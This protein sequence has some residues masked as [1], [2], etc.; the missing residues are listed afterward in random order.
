MRRWLTWGLGLVAAAALGWPV[1][2]DPGSADRSRAAFGEVYR[3]LLS[4]RCRNCHPDGDAPLQ[5]DEGVTHAQNITRRSAASGLPCTACHRDRNAPM[6]GGPPGVPGWDLPPAETP[7]IF[8]GRS[9]RQLCE[10]LKDAS[11]T[12]GRDLEALFEH[13]ATDHLV[14]WGWHP[15]PGRTTPPLS[16]EDF[17]TAFRAWIDGGAAC[18]VD[19]VRGR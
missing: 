19:R 18:P 9:P 12:G 7:M 5:R 14:L 10:Q 11:A 8:E 4:P 17:V 13:I 3:V 1:A 6:R 15:G 2:A 16:H